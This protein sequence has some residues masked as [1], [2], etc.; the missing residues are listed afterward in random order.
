MQTARS[1]RA[2]A[3]EPASILDLA[4]DLPR[5][6]CAR[7]R[8][9]L[10]RA[11]LELFVPVRAHC[12]QR[13]RRPLRRRAVSP[14]PARF[15]RRAKRAVDTRGARAPRQD[16]QPRRGA[17]PRPSAA[18]S[19]PSRSGGGYRGLDVPLQIQPSAVRRSLRCGGLRLFDAF[20]P[21]R[22]ESH[23]RAPGARL[24]WAFLRARVSLPT[25]PW[26]VLGGY[27]ARV[28]SRSRFM[29]DQ[30]R[31]P[32]LRS[33]LLATVPELDSRARERRRRLQARSRPGS[34]TRYAAPR[35]IEASF[36]A[37]AGWRWTCA[38]SPFDEAHSAASGPRLPPPAYRNLAGLKAPLRGVPV[39]RLGVWGTG[40]HQT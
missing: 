19:S 4:R 1:P 34:P 3:R 13:S 40:A 23:G 5:R 2:G 17:D 12:P 28:P 29:K 33:A 38:S 25:I 15:V 26:S 31:R 6:I 32:S 37:R 10:P 14:E 21:G 8:D 11:P 36:W 39:L 16:H 35:G 27:D 30:V 9:V 20:P 18:R 24:A 7:L 22:R